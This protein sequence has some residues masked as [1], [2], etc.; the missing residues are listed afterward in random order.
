LT[1]TQTPASRAL[2]DYGHVDFDHPQCTMDLVHRINPHRGHMV[3]LSGVAWW[4]DNHG[5]GW[6]DVRD[7]EFWVDGHIPGRPLYPGVLMIEA[8]AQLSSFVQLIPRLDD[9]DPKFLGFT[10]CDDAVFRGQV[11]PGDRLVLLTD[12]VK[13][14][15][16]RFIS[17][18]QGFVRDQLAFEVTVTGMVF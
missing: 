6:K 3:Q 14:N 9:P 17:R 5:V 8:A 12:L 7:D 10:R 16:R 2:F 1:T 11:V 18:C 4:C 13:R 15:N